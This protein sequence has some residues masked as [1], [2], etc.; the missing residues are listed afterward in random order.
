MGSVEDIKHLEAIL[1]ENSSD[2][3]TRVILADLYESIGDP[4][5]ETLRWMVDNSR[6]PC[7]AL[8]KEFTWSR[9]DERNFDSGLP[10]DVFELLKGSS[11]YWKSFESCREATIAL[12]ETFSEERVATAEVNQ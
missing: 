12:H 4:I 3:D 2:Q 11:E 8:A 1:E 5:A 10:S 6:R 9:V 7:H